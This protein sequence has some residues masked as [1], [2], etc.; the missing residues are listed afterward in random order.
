MRVVIFSD[1]FLPAVNGVS[2]SIFM[3]CKGLVSQGHTVLLVCP[4]YEES[5][6]VRLKGVTILRLPSIPALIYPDL[7]VG[8]LSPALVARIRAFRPDI[9]H[10]MSPGTVGL[11]G[12]GLARAMQWPTISTF[13]GYFMEPEYLRIANITVGTEYV[14]RFLWGF[15]RVFFCSTDA[16]ICPTAFVKNDLRRHRFGKPLHICSNGIEID[17]S[18]KRKKDLA[19]F[20]ATFDIKPEQTVLYVGR[21]SAEK[22]LEELI[23]CFATILPTIPAAKLLL[24]GDGPLLKP[25]MADVVARKLAGKVIFT[26]AIPHEDLLEIGIYRAAAVF[27][28]CS[29]SEVQPMTMI[30]ATAFGVPLVVYKARGAGD[31]VDGNGYAIRSGNKK[32]FSQALIKML[33][34]P[35]LQARYSKKAIEIA[36]RYDVSFAT[37]SMVKVYE[38]VLKTT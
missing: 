5:E 4:K 9:V 10:L 29:T 7:Y 38:K 33:R 19:S 11:E 20:L 24:I 22:G 14:S 8:T 15:A 27:A 3:L 16:I 32:G 34:S 23:D 2:T 30:E 21:M 36:K 13:H 25:L 28:S 18:M 26:G 12:L 17:T 35:A 1:T 37:A 6:A 31:M